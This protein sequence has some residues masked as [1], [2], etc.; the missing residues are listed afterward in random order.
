MHTDGSGILDDA[1]PQYQRALALNPD[2]WQAHANL[3]YIFMK[4][5]ELDKSVRQLQE[6]VRLQPESTALRATL[7]EATAALQNRGGPASSNR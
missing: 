4:R 7:A 5:G 6:A 3:G 1:V 2:L